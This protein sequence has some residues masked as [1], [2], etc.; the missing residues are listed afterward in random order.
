MAKI[1]IQDLPGDMSI[2]YE[3][4]RK[5]HGGIQITVDVDDEVNFLRFLSRKTKTTLKNLVGSSDDSSSGGSGS[6]PTVTT[7]ETSSVS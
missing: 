7:F 4:M 5:I 6:K 3:E 2:S 1:Q